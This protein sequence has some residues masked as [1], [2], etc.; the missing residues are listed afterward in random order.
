MNIRKARILE[1]AGTTA[2]LNDATCRVEGKRHHLP[3][4]GSRCRSSTVTLALAI[5]IG[6]KIGLNW[7]RFHFFE[8][9]EIGE[10]VNV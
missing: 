2:L 5:E 7:V 4:I 10:I 3:T 8:K 9:V 1:C 6:F